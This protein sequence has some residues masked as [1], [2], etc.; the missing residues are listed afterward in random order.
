MRAFRKCTFIEIEGLFNQKLWSFSNDILA[1]FSR[2]YPD[3]SL[4]FLKSLDH[5][6]PVYCVF[7]TTGDVQY[8]GGIP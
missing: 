4:I 5:D 7:S 1:Y 6:H 8:I 2:F 3:L